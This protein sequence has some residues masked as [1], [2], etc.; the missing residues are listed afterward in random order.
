MVKLVTL[1]LMWQVSYMTYGEFEAKFSH[2]RC[3]LLEWTV[4]V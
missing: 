2:V 4:A 1:V 3:E